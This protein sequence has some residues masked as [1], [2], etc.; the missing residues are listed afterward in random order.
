MSIARRLATVL[1]ATTLL[2]LLAL[3]TLLTLLALLSLLPLLSLLSLLT[4]LLS[5]LSLLLL[6]RG[7]F[8]ARGLVGGLLAVARRGGSSGGVA[9][10]QDDRTYANYRGF[11]KLTRHEL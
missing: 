9:V 7:G 11:G 8:S 3:L 10:L 4:R 2:A 1:R 5:L 6:L